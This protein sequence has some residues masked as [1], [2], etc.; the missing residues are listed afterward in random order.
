MS[1]RAY[2]PTAFSS[3]PRL[4]ITMAFWHA[5]STHQVHLVDDE[6]RRP[7]TFLESVEHE[8]VAGTRRFRRLDQEENQVYLRNSMERGLDH[9]LIEPELGLVDAGRVHEHQLGAGQVLDAE[10]PRP[11][12]LRLVRDDGDLAAENAVQECRLSHVRPAYQRDEAGVVGRGRAHGRSF[13]Y[14][15]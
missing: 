7:A 9:P 12:R 15:F 13:G 1:M 8:P 4:P 14:P 11:G 3:S 2:V 10:N 5:F 6:E